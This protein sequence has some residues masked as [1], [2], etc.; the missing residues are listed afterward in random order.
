MTGPVSIDIVFDP[1]T[2]AIVRAEWNALEA[3]GLSSLAAYKDASNRPHI[4]IIEGIADDA[5][6][7][8][9]NLPAL[10]PLTV[11][12]GP[13]LLF[14][15]G[16]RRVLA[17]SVVP[18]AGLLQLRATVLRLLD[19]A[20]DGTWLPHVTLARRIQVRS[21]EAALELI[22]ADITGSATAMRQWNS[23]TRTLTEPGV[24]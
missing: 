2:E 20:D 19:T 7:R 8:L 6:N 9:H 5:A 18:T 11:T 16:P 12:L 13:P 22:G 10:L 3:H 24:G 21:V 15:S 1:E 14:G 4:S 23:D 17:R